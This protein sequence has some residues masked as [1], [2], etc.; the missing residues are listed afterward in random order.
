MYVTELVQLAHE[1]HLDKLAIPAIVKRH[2]LEI[3]AAA[4]KKNKGKA[5]VAGAAA[6]VLPQKTV[7]GA[8]L[9][10]IGG[11]AMDAESGLPQVVVDTIAYVR[12]H[13][14]DVEGI[15]RRSA[16]AVTVRSWLAFSSFICYLWVFFW[17]RVVSS[18]PRMRD[19]S[20]VLAMH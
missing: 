8:S 7:F 11:A 20:M 3:A 10:A 18:R 1:I 17:E 19:S 15:F 14:L 2:D 5:G 4:A 13:G 9:A 16:S 12:A 6:A